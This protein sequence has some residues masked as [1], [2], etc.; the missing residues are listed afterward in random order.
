MFYRE[1]QTKL[2]QTQSRPQEEPKLSFPRTF[3]V[4]TLD[5]L[6]THGHRHFCDLVFNLNEMGVSEWEDRKSKS[7]I[8]RID[9]K[10]RLIRPSWARQPRKRAVRQ[11]SAFSH[12][13]EKV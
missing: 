6:Q 8:I 10:D 3:L 11:I 4:R 1:E 5:A 13:R 12:F 7:V 9:M 2:W